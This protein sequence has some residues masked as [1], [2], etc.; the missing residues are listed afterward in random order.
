MLSG[1]VALGYRRAAGRTTVR[2]EPVTLGRPFR[3]LPAV[4]LAGMLTLALLVGRWWSAVLGPKGVVLAAGGTG[5]ADAHA[6]AIASA[7]LFRQG[8]VGLAA[9]LLAVAASLAANTVTK[10]VLAFAAGGREFGLRYTAVVAPVVALV[11]GGLA[12]TAAL[13]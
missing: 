11:V 12:L 13:L 10:C 2:G 3:L 7:S 5:L 1:V 6:G 9:A 8:Q 4:V